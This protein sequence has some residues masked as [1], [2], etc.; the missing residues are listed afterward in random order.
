MDVL[1]VVISSGVIG[2]GVLF[3]FSSRQHA[4]KKSQE[5]FNRS[6]QE[7]ERFSYW[8]FAKMSRP[9]ISG[10]LYKVLG[11]VLILGGVLHLLIGSY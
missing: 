11:A 3:L 9:L 6:F 8:L 1:N 5:Q 4:L 2:L 10:V 7:T